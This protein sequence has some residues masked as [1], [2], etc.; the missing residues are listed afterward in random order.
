MVGMKLE[1]TYIGRHQEM[2]QQW[3]ALQPLMEVCDQETGYKGGG[4]CRRSRWRQ[5][6]T[7][8]VLRTTLEEALWV[9]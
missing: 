6:A 3:L 4:R 7:A 2:V 1:A 9:G 5:G 8:E